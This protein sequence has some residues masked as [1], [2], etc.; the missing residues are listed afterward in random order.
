MIVKFFLHGTTKSGNKSAKSVKGYL[1]NDKRV[2]EQTARIIQRLNGSDDDEF[3][4]SQM[5]DFC[6]QHTDFKSTYTAGCL[7]FD[8]QESQHTTKNKP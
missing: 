2:T 7:S 8:E 3:L 4:T 1:L 5:I 6:D